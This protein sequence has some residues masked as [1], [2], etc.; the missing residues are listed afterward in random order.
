MVTNNNINEEKGD[1]IVNVT[2]C[3]ITNNNDSK[4]SVS[5]ILRK[6]P[7]APRKLRIIADLIR[8]KNAERAMSI[9]NCNQKKC[10]IYIKKLLISAIAIFNKNASDTVDCSKLIINTIKVDGGSMLKRLLPAPQGR[11]YRIRKRSSHITL[12][13]K[14]I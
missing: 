2:D 4:E 3:K 6:C 10:C 7:I 14:H 12:I 1:A 8:K 13:L 11:G 9:L 5:V